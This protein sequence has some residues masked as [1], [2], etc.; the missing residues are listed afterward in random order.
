MTVRKPNNSDKI[1]DV[2]R[3][4]DEVFKMRRIRIGK[5]D[6]IVTCP[7]CNVTG[8]EQPDVVA[9]LLTLGITYMLE[10]IDPCDCEYC[11]GEG[12]IIIERR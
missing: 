8:C 12:Q 6:E 7:E 4:H 1:I 11:G 5:N 2:V 9:G 3:L 10:S